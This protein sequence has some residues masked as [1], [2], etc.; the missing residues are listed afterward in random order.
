MFRNLTILLLINEVRTVVVRIVQLRESNVE[1]ERGVAFDTTWY[2]FAHFWIDAFCE[3]FE[4]SNKN[5][6]K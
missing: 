5:F 1:G 6:N 3:K 4:L 2:T